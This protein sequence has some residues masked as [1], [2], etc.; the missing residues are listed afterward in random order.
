L[1][2]AGNGFIQILHGCLI[3][4]ERQMHEPPPQ[5]LNQVGGVG[6]IRGAIQADNIRPSFRQGNCH[7]LSQTA[8]CTCDQRNFAI[9]SERIQN[10]HEFALRC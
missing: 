4:I 1:N 9:Q 6:T 8:P 10:A 3:Q 2:H 5:S 7:C